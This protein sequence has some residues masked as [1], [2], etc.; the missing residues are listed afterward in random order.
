MYKFRSGRISIYLTILIALPLWAK[1][2]WTCD[3]GRPYEPN[4]RALSLNEILKIVS[5]FDRIMDHNPPSM[6]DF[7]YL[8]RADESDDAEIHA[9]K[10]YCG[11]IRTIPIESFDC[12]K[13]LP[14]D[15]SIYL[16]NIKNLLTDSKDIPIKIYVSPKIKSCFNNSQPGVAMNRLPAIAILGPGKFKRIDIVIPCDTYDAYNYTMVSDVKIDGKSARDYPFTITKPLS[17]IK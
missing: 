11:N 6:C 14:N 15:P 16:L 10:Q 9:R 13:Y 12:G 17:E 7:N 8:Y 4:H 5:D 3:S 2:E 1:N